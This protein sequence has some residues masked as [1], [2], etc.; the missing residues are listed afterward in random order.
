VA[1]KIYKFNIGWYVTNI[2]T[3]EPNFQQRNST[4]VTKKWR[5]LLM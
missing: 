1:D 2:N 3:H 5:I 4:I